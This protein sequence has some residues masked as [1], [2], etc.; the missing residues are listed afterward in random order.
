M[1]SPT[2]RWT[3]LSTNINTNE[4]ADPRPTAVAIGLVPTTVDAMTKETVVIVAMIV[5]ATV[6]ANSVIAAVEIE[7]EIATTSVDAIRETESTIRETT[8]EKEIEDAI[9]V[10]ESTSTIGETPENAIETRR[11]RVIDSLAETTTTTR[12][13]VNEVVLARE[14][15]A[16][17]LLL[18]NAWFWMSSVVWFV[19]G[20]QAKARH[21]GR[22]RQRRADATVAVVATRVLLRQWTPELAEMMEA[23]AEAAAAVVVAVAVLGRRR[24][25]ANSR[26]NQ[27]QRRR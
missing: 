24:T 19:G 9:R 6:I 15:R 16:T 1:I 23:P 21:R 8:T 25:R 17:A 3:T 12:T 5:I 14:H 20:D 4:V 27:V 18:R 13:K 2:A 7:I 22:R 10:T 26:S 11:E